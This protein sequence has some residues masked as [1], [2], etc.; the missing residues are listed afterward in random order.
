MS[1]A[2][3][4]R[5]HDFSQL[6]GNKQVI[7]GLQKMLEENT[8]PHALLFSGDS[9]CGKT[10]IGRIVA[11]ELGCSDKDFSEIDSADFRGID[12]VRMLRQQMRYMPIDGDV[13][14]WLID[15]CHKMT[16]DAQNALLKALEEPPAHIYFILCT[17]DPHKLLATIKSRCTK[18]V[19][20]SPPPRLLV[21]HLIRIAKKEGR[22]DIP[23][24]VFEDIVDANHARPRA[25]ISN[26]EKVLAVPEGG[27]FRAVLDKTEVLDRAAMDLGSQL[28][29][30]GNWAD[31]KPL[32]VQIKKE[33]MDPETV[34]RQLRAY[35]TTVLLKSWNE[36]A[37]ITLE[38]FE[39][40][41]IDFPDLVKVCFRLCLE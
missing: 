34:R 2:V 14:V 7:A 21:R 15:E 25:C 36:R 40:G 41:P 22:S 9:G 11:N 18:F 4:Y 35:M 3:K 33:N 13:R 28:I 30:G 23:M 38:E 16:N 31:I 39:E 29:K 26:L 5:P 17:T 6:V 27:N 37:G 1:L 24:E 19:M 10:T 32:L 20:T 8:L 12:T